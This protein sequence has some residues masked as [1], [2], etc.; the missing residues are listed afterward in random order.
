MLLTPLINFSGIVNGSSARACNIEED[1]DVFCR[2]VH[3]PWF[4]THACVSLPQYMYPTSPQCIAFPDS[5]PDSVPDTISLSMEATMLS[6][7]VELL[8]DVVSRLRTRDQ[9]SIGLGC[10]NLH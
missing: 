2:F 6:L 7:P 3:V 1:L 8:I 4:R 10:R 9:L 5:A